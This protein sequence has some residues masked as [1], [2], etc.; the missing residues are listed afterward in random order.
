MFYKMMTVRA[1][2]KHGRGLEGKL[3][4]RKNYKPARKILTERTMINEIDG[5]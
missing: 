1:A 2:I 3:R 5:L 4:E